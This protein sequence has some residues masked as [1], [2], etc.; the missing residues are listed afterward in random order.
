MLVEERKR[1]W[2]TNTKVRERKKVCKNR[3]EKVRI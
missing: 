1:E 2:E 3:R